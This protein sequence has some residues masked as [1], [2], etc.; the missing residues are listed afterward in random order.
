MAKGQGG[1]GGLG[2]KFGDIQRRMAEMQES[3][4]T[5]VVDG[6]SGGGVVTALVN[7][8]KELV[9]I[10]IDPSA[11]DPD[12]VEMLEDLIIAAVKQGMDKAEQMASEEMAKITGGLSLP[13]M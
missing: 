4:K 7:G 3:L 2:K 5:R 13:G 11:V 1:M 10:K 6:S 9:S 12:D 8:R